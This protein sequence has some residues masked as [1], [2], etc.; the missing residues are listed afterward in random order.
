MECAQPRMVV[1]IDFGTVAAAAAVAVAANIYHPRSF[2]DAGQQSSYEFERC[3]DLSALI[4]VRW[5]MATTTTMKL[6]GYW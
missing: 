1:V 2:A 4:A 3:R 6:T 5:L